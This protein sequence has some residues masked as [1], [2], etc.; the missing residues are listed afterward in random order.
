MMATAARN[1]LEG[2]S[3]FSCEGVF[4]KEAQSS[5][6]V[7]SNFDLLC[8]LSVSAVCRGDRYFDNTAA[9]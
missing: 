6:R 7:C 9:F 4:T 2:A 8:A 1:I 5:Q 3:G